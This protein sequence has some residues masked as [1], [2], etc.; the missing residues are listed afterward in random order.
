MAANRIYRPLGVAALAV[1]TVIGL[2]SSGLLPANS[3]TVVDDAGQL[4]AGLA[5]VVACGWTGLRRSGAERSW[6]LLMALAMLGWSAGQAI[7]SWYQIFG[8]EPLASP[9]VADVGSFMLPVFAVPALLVLAKEGTASPAGSRPGR[10]SHWLLLLDGVV[11]VGSLFI[12]TWST[13][14]G[15]TARAGAPTWPAFVVAVGYPITDLVLVVMVVLLIAG[16][17]GAR[18]RLAQLGVLGLG[19]VGISVSDSIYTYLVTTGAVATPPIAN[20]GFVAGPALIAVAGA[21]RVRDRRR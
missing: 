6:R 17:Q 9:S 15:A 19:L 2:S 11:V 3:S 21:V 14:L 8:P 20:V 5:A 18:P 13:A 4:A 12:V 1:V 16:Y 10:R 7:W